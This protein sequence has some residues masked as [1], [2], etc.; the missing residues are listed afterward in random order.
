[1]I[2]A[3]GLLSAKPFARFTAYA[4]RVRKY[5]AARS[6]RYRRD[7]D[8]IQGLN[9]KLPCT[10]H[11]ASQRAL[12]GSWSHTMCMCECENCCV[13]SNTPIRE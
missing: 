7:S 9:E 10:V 13:I 11:T 6:A 5:G 1:M 4:L 8:S 2:L 3:W 12:V